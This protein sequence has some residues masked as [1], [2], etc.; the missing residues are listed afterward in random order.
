MKQ[1]GRGKVTTLTASYERP[2]RDGLLTILSHN[3]LMPKGTKLL[4]RMTR[5]LPV[6]NPY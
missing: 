6:A 3:F 4:P 5:M 1:G 2:D